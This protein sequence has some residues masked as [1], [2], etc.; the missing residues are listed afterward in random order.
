MEI[1]PGMPV[2]SDGMMTD[3]LERILEGSGHGLLEVLIQNF[4]G[5]TEEI[6]EEFSQ[7]SSYPS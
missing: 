2:V 5:Q 3:E 4:P 7:D 6:T 1:I